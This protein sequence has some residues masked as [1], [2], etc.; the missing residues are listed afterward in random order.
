MAGKR[1]PNGF[2]LIEVL[3]AMGLVAVVLLGTAEMLIRAVQIRGSAEERLNLIEA[4]CSQLERLKGADPGSTDLEIGSHEAAVDAGSKGAIILIW[5]VEEAGPG[6]W[7]LSC[8]A[9]GARGVGSTGSE[10][11]RVRVSVLVSRQLGF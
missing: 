10:R 4:S 9:A 1:G 11:N 5:T 3:L 2:A 8:A 7:K 6:T